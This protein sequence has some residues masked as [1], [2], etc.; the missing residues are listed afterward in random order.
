MLLE[1]TN[2]SFS[3]DKKSPIF[4]NINISLESTEQVCLFAKSGFG[5]ST[6]AKV[7]SGY[8]KPSSGQILIDKKPIKTT[9]FNPVQLIYQHPEK[10]VNPRWRMKDVLAEAQV[11]NAI[12]D[13]LHIDKKFLTRY[14][15][16]LSAG[17]LQKF[18]IARALSKDTN[19]LIADEIT[20]MLDTITQAHIWNVLLEETKKRNIGLLVVTHNKF[21]GDK[22]CSRVIN[23][24]ELCQT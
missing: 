10:A 7:L 22:V 19:F 21:L 20:T 11:D 13:K 8:E 18:C 16:E 9:G 17:Q 2:L 5:K 3:Y 23:L 12:L 1:A 24:E 4:S 6:L 15:E 14:P